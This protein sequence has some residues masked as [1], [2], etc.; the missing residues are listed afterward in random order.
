M[1][2]LTRTIA[3][4]GAA[5][6]PP[7]AAWPELQRAAPA[8]HAL[9]SDQRTL[10]QQFD[11]SLSRTR[12]DTHARLVPAIQARLRALRPG[13]RPPTDAEVALGV[14]RIERALRTSPLHIGFLSNRANLYAGSQAFFST[15]V[16][17]NTYVRG[18]DAE[19]LPPER[20]DR[21]I[22]SLRL[23]R[24]QPLY[25]A[26]NFSLRGHKGWGDSCLVLKPHL[27]EQATLGTRDSGDPDG[28]TPPVDGTARHLLP[29][30]EDW[31]NRPFFQ[32]HWA[33]LAGRERTPIPW[34]VVDAGFPIEARMFTPDGCLHP[35]DIAMVCV[36]FDELVTPEGRLGRGSR[37]DEAAVRERLDAFRRF[38]AMT[39]VPVVVR[40]SGALGESF[41]QVPGYGK[42][43]DAYAA[44]L[45]GL[46]SV[47]PLRA[48]PLHY[49]QLLAR[50]G[51][52]SPSASTSRSLAL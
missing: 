25:G 46:P 41:L 11:A 2:G 13:E 51:L 16:Y 35:R 31:L 19:E 21:A 49:T 38:E 37:V 40:P 15:G 12:G 9:S 30:I 5:S 27:L 44:H 33:A 10:L 3:G 22:K 52:G 23:G 42:V 36:D 32:T 28:W 8:F 26:L 20:R 4:L 1:P 45:D 14:R 34:N 48:S 39:G 24:E 17:E 18:G 6:L 29:I 50:C 43:I 7:G 47:A